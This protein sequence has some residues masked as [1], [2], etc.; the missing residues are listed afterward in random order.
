MRSDGCSFPPG[1]PHTMHQMDGR[2]QSAFL[3]LATGSTMAHPQSRHLSMIQGGSFIKHS[4]KHRF[5]GRPLLFLKQ[6][7]RKEGLQNAQWKWCKVWVWG[8]AE[9]DWWSWTRAWLPQNLS[10]FLSFLCVCV[11]SPPHHFWFPCPVSIL[12]AVHLKAKLLLVSVP[13]KKY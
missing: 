6:K 12:G 3:H 5:A 10:R 13:R 7:H 1:G 4:A 9:T 2:T 11:L 8:M